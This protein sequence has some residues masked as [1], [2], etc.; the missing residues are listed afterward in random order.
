MV[1]IW[2]LIFIIFTKYSHF[3]RQNNIEDKYVNINDNNGHIGGNMVIFGT[4]PVICWTNMVLF[5]RNSVI[6]GI[7]AIIVWT[8]MATLR[9]IEWLRDKYCYI[10]DKSTQILTKLIIFDRKMAIQITNTVIFWKN[11]LLLAN[12][13]QI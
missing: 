6:F 12:F 10:W 13:W 4:E 9:K 2:T 1:I 7:N 5:G 3:N 8:N 11:R